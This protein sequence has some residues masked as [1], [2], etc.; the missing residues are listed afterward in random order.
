MRKAIIKRITFAFV[1][2]DRHGQL[3]RTSNSYF[4]YLQG[5]HVIQI[6]K[7]KARPLDSARYRKPTKVNYTETN[8]GIYTEQWGR[9]DCFPQ[10]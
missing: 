5:S 7:K 1:V 2:A 3:E 6:V 8:S 9:E 4:G 10:T